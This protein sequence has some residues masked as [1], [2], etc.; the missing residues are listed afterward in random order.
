[1]I[2]LR[3]MLNYMETNFRKGI[4]VRDVASSVGYSPQHCNHLFKTYFGDSIGS[5]LRQLRLEAAKQDLKAGVPVDQVRKELSFSSS[6]AFRTAFHERFGVSPL[7]YAQGAEIREP[8]VKTYE[9]RGER[10]VWGNGIN[11]TPDG[12]WEFSYYDLQEKAYHLMDWTDAAFEAPYSSPV[13]ADPRW[14]CLQRMAGYEMHSS[15]ICHA[16][17]SFVC[18]YGGEIELFFSVGRRAKVV[19]RGSPCEVR[20]LQN[21]SPLVIPAGSGLLNRVNPVYLSAVCRVNAGDRIRLVLD[22]RGNNYR[23]SI[24]LY[25]QRIRYLQIDGIGSEKKV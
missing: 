5:Y 6:S 9:W 23:D 14:Y 17:R 3:R 12:L 13:G 11:P 4:S 19:K 18:P 8:Y 2:D 24:Y 20:L 15:R 1:M 7:R 10:D 25:R 21:D 22:A 16:V